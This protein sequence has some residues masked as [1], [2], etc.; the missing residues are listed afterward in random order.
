MTRCALWACAAIAAVAAVLTLHDLG[1]A[2]IC[3]GNEAHDGMTVQLMVEQGELL[4]PL[5]G[6]IEPIAKPPLFHWT[7]TALHT[8]LGIH[9]VT[10]RSLRLAA[11]LYAVAGVVLTMAF[12]W[13]ALGPRGAVLAGLALVA[14]HYYIEKGRLG[15][16]DMTLTFFESLGIFSFAWW[17][18]GGGVAE[19]SPAPTGSRRSLMLYL[20]AL[21]LGLAVL[22]KG[23]IG[24]I[25]P[26]LTILAYLAG[27][28][29]W[30]DLRALLRP[31]PIALGLIIASSW[32]VASY[33][34]GY[35]Q[36][37]RH[38]LAIENYG[39]FV[40]ALGTMPPWF[41]VGRAVMQSPVIS[42]IAVIAVLLVLIPVLPLARELRNSSSGRVRTSVQLLA[43]F[44]AV[45]FIFFSIAAYKSRVYLLPLYPSAAILVA[46]IV[47]R[48]SEIRWGARLR[49]AYGVVC[50]ALVVGIFFHLPWAAKRACEG[51]E[52]AIAAQRVNEVVPRDRPLYLFGFSRWAYELQFHLHR[53]TGY[54]RRQA[55][56][57][58]GIY[59]LLPAERWQSLARRLPANDP[60]LIY[61][62]TEP[63]VVV[64]RTRDRPSPPGSAP[65]AAPNAGAREP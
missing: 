58:S 2:D 63:K 38:Q 51:R 22:S 36:N 18:D 59:V 35:S 64:V 53:D 19:G 50:F 33:L 16:V 27:R 3:F 31:G 49:A 47:D 37:P 6:G 26:S 41:Y 39:R 24:A 43:T 48:A 17:L 21:A 65:A 44:W 5:P 54:I 1:G 12:A 57:R 23:P 11:A 29:R 20:A 62:D 32:Y 45:T 15:R 46:W 42:A 56:I 4:S 7:S 13:W 14:S 28:R 55:A 60:V 25:I 40:G 8:L 52:P 61:T 10:P 9:K 30:K 34:T